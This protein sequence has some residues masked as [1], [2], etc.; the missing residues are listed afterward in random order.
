MASPPNIALNATPP[1]ANLRKDLTGGAVSAAV[2]I[3]LAMAFGMFA[4]VPLGDEYFAY[5]AMAGLYAALI[6]AIVNV[7]LGQRGTTLYAPRVTTTF[8][9]GGLLLTLV[10]SDVGANRQVVLL[11][12]YA[13][14]LL[15][16]A[17]QASFGLMRLGSL[18]RFM[19][20]PVMAGFQNAAAALLFLVQL[21][22]VCGFDR[23][24]S[25]MR[26]GTHLHEIKPLT[27]LV[28]AVTFASMWEAR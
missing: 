16:G 17:F 21:G 10:Q 13:I 23:S 12:F 4:F 19:P 14:V 11:A 27:L 1:L 8:I 2:A 25:F 7:A 20:Q 18:L 24:V 26:I 15:A 3:P 5:G 22:N 28:A 6:V 9:L